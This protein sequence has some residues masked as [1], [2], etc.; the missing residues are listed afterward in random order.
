MGGAPDRAASWSASVYYDQRSRAEGPGDAANEAAVSEFLPAPVGWIDPATGTEG[1][2]LWARR[3]SSEQA[4]SRRYDYPATIVLVEITGLD[5]LAGAWGAE[6]AERTFVRL[7][8][9]LGGEIRSSDH[10][11]RLER[12][13]FAVLLT[14]TDE[15]AA[16]NFVERARKGCEASLGAAGQILHVAFGWANPPNSGDLATAIELAAQ[17]LAAELSAPR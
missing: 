10:L 14:Q 5:E 8:N 12:T 9:T 17:R 4:R 2:L 1:P 11:A 3:V 16:I 6:V 13:R 15:I 7:A